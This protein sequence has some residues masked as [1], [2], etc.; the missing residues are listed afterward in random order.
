MRTIQLEHDYGF[1]ETKE[2]WGG[3]FLTWEA[4]PWGAIEVYDGEEGED[5][6]IL[7]PGSSLYDGEPLAYV[8]CNAFP[9]DQV[10]NCLKTIEDTTTMRA[11]ASTSI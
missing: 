1:E 2:K 7:K 5:T 4:Y 10:F 8:V 6:C 3:K 11:N 9:D